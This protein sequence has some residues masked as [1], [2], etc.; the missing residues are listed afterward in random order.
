MWKKCAFPAFHKLLFDLFTNNLENG[1]F[2]K[3]L[4]KNLEIRTHRLRD[5]IIKYK[6]NEFKETRTREKCKDRQAVYDAWVE[7]SIPS[8]DD[9]NGQN[10]VA[11]SKRH[12]LPFSD[13]TN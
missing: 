11:T 6:N 4:S 9:R 1:D 5:G 10:K 8:T 12:Y 13:L 7:N 2:L 3:W